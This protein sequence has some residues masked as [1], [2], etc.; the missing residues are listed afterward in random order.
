MNGSHRVLA[1]NPPHKKLVD[2]NTHG[3]TSRLPFTV[4]CN[5]WECW[6]KK[7]KKENKLQPSVHSPILVLI[8][9]VL[10][11]KPMRN[12]MQDRANRKN[13]KGTLQGKTFTREIIHE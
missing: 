9:K 4:F 12:E 2:A 5:A 7:R 8:Y 11:V 1:H 6:Q 10:L 13:N 3:V